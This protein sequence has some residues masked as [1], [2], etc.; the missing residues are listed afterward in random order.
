MLFLEPG[1]RGSTE[2]SLLLLGAVV[3]A[4]LGISYV[5]TAAPWRVAFA[6]LVPSAFMTSAS[7]LL[8][9]PSASRRLQVALRALTAS[10]GT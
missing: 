3:L 10:P 9:L 7:V 5:G 2:R 4:S 6:Y 8:A 1:R